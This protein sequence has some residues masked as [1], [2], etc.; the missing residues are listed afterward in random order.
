ML[1]QARAAIRV[2][3]GATLLEP[4]PMSLRDTAFAPVQ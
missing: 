3:D 1:H 4:S 2:D